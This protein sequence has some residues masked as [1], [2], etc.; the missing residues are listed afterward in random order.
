MTR[1]VLRDRVIAI[2]GATGGLGRA[3][4]IALRG[5]GAKLVLLDLDRDSLNALAIDLG[6]PGVAAGWVADARSLQSLEAALK[7]AAGH[8]G[9][10]DVVIAGAGI[11]SPESLES[12]EPAAFDRVVDINLNGVWR[13]FRAALPYVK[14]RQGYLLAISSMAAFVHSPLNAHYTASKAGVWALCDSIRLELKPQGVG[15]GSLHPTFFQTPM[16][17]AVIDHPCSALVWNSHRGIW[18]FVA[19][20]QVVA[21]LVDCIERRR[22][23][24]TVPS[25]NGMV[26]KTC[27]LLR[28]LIERIGFEP[29][30]VAEA[31]RLTNTRK[32]P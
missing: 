3:A 19:L 12:M 9:G 29:S 17:E 4:A 5:K 30:K 31:V 11:G 8:F 1:Y 7:D 21:S 27:G 14:A 32:T 6:G 16:M 26:A 25:S 18:K 28:R 13:T 10:I 24:V 23:L 15:V 22:D 2:T 20:D